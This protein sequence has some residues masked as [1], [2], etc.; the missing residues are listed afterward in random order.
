M[1]SI[2]L[3]HSG[4]NS[5]SLNPPTAAP[6]PGGG[7]TELA[8]KLPSTYGSSGEFMQTDG[9]GNLSF[10]SGT[11]T[12]IAQSQLATG[13]GGKVIQCKYHQWNNIYS[14]TNTDDLGEEMDSS[15]RLTITP[16][17]NNSLIVYSGKFYIG[18]NTNIVGHVNLQKSSSTDMSS[19]SLVYD[20]DQTIT[21]RSGDNFGNSILY[22]YS[23]GFMMDTN[24]QVMEI[25]GST[26]ARTYSPFWSASSSGTI[27][28]NAYKYQSSEYLY[29]G[30]SSILLQEIVI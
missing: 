29:V 28:N 14:T 10:A 20:H 26:T 6:N 23:S 30:T 9:A 1:S 13:V 7:G 24:L 22:G 27:W 4:G 2:K 17:L 11:P 12:N 21:V 8:L 3:K 25:S 5:V 19:P 15:L 18:T 16:I